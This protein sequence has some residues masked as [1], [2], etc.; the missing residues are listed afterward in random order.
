MRGVYHSDRRG[1]RDFLPVAVG[2]QGIKW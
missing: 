1:D 2:E